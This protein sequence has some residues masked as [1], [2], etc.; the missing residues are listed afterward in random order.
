MGHEQDLF[1]AISIL[2]QQG[3]YA[4]LEFLGG[5]R[6]GSQPV[7]PKRMHRHIEPCAGQ[8]IVRG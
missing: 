2:L 6:I 4:F 5:I 1:A 8:Q 3:F 7:I